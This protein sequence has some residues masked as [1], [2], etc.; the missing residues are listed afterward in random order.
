MTFK[1]KPPWWGG[2]L[3]TIRNFLCAGNTTLPG[4]SKSFLIPTTDGSGDEITATLDMPDTP[5]IG[6]LIILIHGL[7]GSEDS[8]YMLATSQYH[9]KQGRQVLRLN[10]RGAGSSAKR[11]REHYHGGHISD[12]SDALDYLANK[13]KSNGIFLIG[14]SLGGNIL[15]N[16]LAENN[17]LSLLGAASV[18]ASIDPK[19]AA[20]R[21]LSPRNTLYQSR[22][23][24]HMKEENLASKPD[25]PK[26]E[27][28]KLL[29]IKS[30][31]EFDDK[32]TGPNN[33]YKDAEDYYYRTNSARK[34]DSILVPLL[35][36]NARND[37]WI[38]YEPYE[39][40]KQNAPHNVKVVITD[41]GGHVG[42]HE[43][44]QNETWHD[45]QIG[46]FISG[47]N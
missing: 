10:L 17:H 11:C 13:I 8:A 22:L 39:V 43:K 40:V 31:Y 3:Q 36:I 45:R 18:S 41:S 33:G 15:L 35:M 34:I 20:E 21:L 9:L 42:F 38:P 2:D 12:I 30:I 26:T 19:A 37:P 7:T 28:E 32:I 25:L 1:E 6:P 23:L 16:F 14:F 4:N 47:L 24:R 44:G 46:K 29:N 5:I 27:K